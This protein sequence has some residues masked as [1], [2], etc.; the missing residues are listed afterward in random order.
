M[1]ANILL[2][3]RTGTMRR[4]D[5]FVWRTEALNLKILQSMSYRCTVDLKFEKLLENNFIWLSGNLQLNSFAE[6]VNNTGFLLEFIPYLI[7]DG[8]DMFFQSVPPLSVIPAKA[9][10]QER[11]DNLSIVVNS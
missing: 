6:I 9:G 2:C 4:V 7:R 1:E 8:N 11:I 5:T 3:F 10:I